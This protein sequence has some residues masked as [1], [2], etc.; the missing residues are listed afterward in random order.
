MSEQEAEEMLLE[1]KEKAE[2][3]VDL[4]YSSII[5]DNRDLA[6]EV[7]ELEEFIDGLNERFQRLA[8]RDVRNDQLDVDEA[9]VMIQL[10]MCSEMIADSARAISDI[11]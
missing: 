9:M 8:I 7:Y 3:M 5:Y 2:F 4:A 6:E 1:M 11:Q 10:A